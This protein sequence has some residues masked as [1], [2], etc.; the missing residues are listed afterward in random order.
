MGDLQVAERAEAGRGWRQHGVKEWVQTL[1]TSL[2]MWRV[3]YMGLSI[4]FTAGAV[5]F[6]RCFRATLACTAARRHCLNP[7]PLPS[8]RAQLAMCIT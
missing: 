6:T 3:A 7:Q 8:K 4:S 2:E 5:T 1:K